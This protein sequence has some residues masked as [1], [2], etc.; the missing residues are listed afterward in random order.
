MSTQAL[1]PV[2]VPRLEEIKDTFSMLLAKAVKV[3]QC[4]SYE[5][6]GPDG[7]ISVVRDDGGVALAAVQVDAKVAAGAGAALTLMP[8]GP[9][10]DVKTSADVFPTH[11]ENFR[12]IANV[13][14]GLMNSQNS[15]HVSLA[16]VIRA[17]DGLPEDVKEIRDDPTRRDVFDLDI[18]GY[19]AGRLYVFV[20]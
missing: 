13:I 15:P 2:P 5:K 19:A 7:I 12:E 17:A 10:K 9:V 8:P 4:K 14:A 11:L 20:K 3:D 16:E 18:P 1:D 6:H